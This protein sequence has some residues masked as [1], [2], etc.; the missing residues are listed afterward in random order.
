L[1]ITSKTICHFFF[2]EIEDFLIV[3]RQKFRKS[4][5]FYL[6]YN[7][8]KWISFLCLLRFEFHYR[9][10]MYDTFYHFILNLRDFWFAH[11]QGKVQKIV[12]LLFHELYYTPKMNIIPFPAS[13]WISLFG[14]FYYFI[15]KLK[16]FWFSRLQRKVPKI[17]QFLFHVCLKTNFPTSIWISLPS[18]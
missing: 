7:S 13:I 18:V 4:F 16:I 11:L 12:K 15:G 5:N 2:F 10:Y 8:L 6:A 14:K 17:V 9:M 3:S 1:C